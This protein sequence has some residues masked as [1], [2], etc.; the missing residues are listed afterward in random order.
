M[1]QGTCGYPD[2]GITYPCSMSTFVNPYTE[3]FHNIIAQFNDDL[4]AYENGTVDSN[5]PI[6]DITN[7]SNSLQSLNA[8]Q[9]NFATGT[10]EYIGLDYSSK[11]LSNFAMQNLEN[12]KLQVRLEVLD[13]N[14]TNSLSKNPSNSVAFY[15]VTGA[16]ILLGIICIFLIT[17]LV[18]L[19]MNSSGSS[20]GVLRSGSR[21]FIGKEFH[22]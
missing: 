14:I 1:A 5:V 12:V 9:S 3:A 19:Y 6:A 11:F 18:Y 7:F 16:T 15:A 2:A 13:T 4:I 22:L 8:F 20:T 10:P 17:Y 21:G